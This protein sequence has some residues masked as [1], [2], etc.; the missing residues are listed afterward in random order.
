MCVREE[1]SALGERRA[2]ETFTFHTLKTKGFAMSWVW[3][4]RLPERT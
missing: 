3:P 2:K 1:I 4:P